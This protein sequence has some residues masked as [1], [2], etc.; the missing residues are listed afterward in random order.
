MQGFSLKP[1]E[2]EDIDVEDYPKAT[3]YLSVL[4]GLP[5]SGWTLLDA[6]HSGCRWHRRGLFLRYRGPYRSGRPPS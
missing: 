3:E 5:S 6:S 4:M 1:E 2:G